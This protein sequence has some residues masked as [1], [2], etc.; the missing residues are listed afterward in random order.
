MFDITASIV[1][2]KNDHDVLG[3]AIE[4]FLNTSL[5]IRLYIVDN[6]ADASTEEFCKKFPLEYFAMPKNAGF[7]AGH[8]F[9][10]RKK[11]LLGKYHLVLNPDVCF[12]ANVPEALFEYMETHLDVGNVMPK[13]FYP[14]GDLQYLCKLL[15]KP[16]NWIGRILI[17][18]KRI[19]KRLDYN[20]EM[21]FTDYN[22]T[23][24]A[25]YLSGCFM[26]LRSEAIRKAGLFDEKIFM[27]GEDTDLNRRIGKHYYTMFYPSVSIIHKY[28][29][30]S[31]KNLRLLLIHIKSAIYYFNKWGWL[32]DSDRT[33]INN[34]IKKQFVEN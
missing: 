14:N 6:S 8:N 10:L 1:T 31:H 30:G 20:F 7:G 32:C 22:H 33:K 29:G 3:K 24:Q 2:Y 12:E 23:M 25:P 13:V 16:G 28:D 27:Y 15:P 11:E 17:P 21:R 5:N 19:R 9:I 34:F 26:F 4:S 18:S